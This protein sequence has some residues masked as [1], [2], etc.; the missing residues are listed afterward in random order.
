MRALCLIRPQLHYR[1]DAFCSGLKAAGYEVVEDLPSPTPKDVLVIWNRYGQYH[2]Q[3]KR[4]EAAGG[5]VVVAENGY[6]GKAW[7]D[8][9]WYAL[10]IGHHAGAGKWKVGGPERWDDLN[11]PLEPWRPAGKELIILGQR[12][13]GEPS[14]AC[15]QSWAHA[16]RMR[17]PGST[18][19]RPHP[20]NLRPP[21]V[22]LRDDLQNAAGVVTWASSAALHALAFGVPVWHD[23]YRWIGAP[24]SKPV[25]A[26]LKS[27][28]PLRDDAARLAMFRRL[29]WAQ[30][31]ISEIASGQAFTHLLRE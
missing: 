6:L 27:E 5:R 16:I 24:A 12:G 25:P 23:M 14:V 4:F 28:E 20:G 18:R 13:I 11:V 1:R 9:T 19:I 22:E 3:A 31:R 30:W 7:L 8:D 17:L 15:D 26:L 21:S 10:A 29:I 2:S